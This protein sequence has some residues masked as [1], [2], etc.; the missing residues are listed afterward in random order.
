VDTPLLDGSAQLPTSPALIVVDVDG[1]LLTTTHEVTP[2]TA[3]E[4]R[5]V[6]ATGV[7][8]LPASSRGPRAMLRALGLP[9][10]FVGSQGA[11]TGGYDAREALRPIGRHPAPLDA[12]RSVVTAAVAAAATWITRSNDDDGVAWALRVLVP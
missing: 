5:R 2:A 10:A 9:A 6:R 1:T 12:V 4:V 3:R 8:V 11:F 7:D